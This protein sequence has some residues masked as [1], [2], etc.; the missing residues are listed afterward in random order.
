M[1]DATQKCPVCGAILPAGA[2]FCGECGTSLRA[3]GAVPAAA[4]HTTNPVLPWFLAGCAVM[5]VHA[6]VI[7]VAVKGRTSAAPVPVESSAAPFAGGGAPSASGAPDISNMTPR[8]A[9]DRLYNRIARASEAGDTAQVAFFAPMAINA[10]ANV[11]PK[12][13]DARLHIGLIQIGIGNT[14]AARAEADTITRQNGLH[15]FG[16]LL[17]ARAAEAS[18]D[19]ATMREAYRAFLANYDAEM[20]KNLPEYE[21]HRNE[22]EAARTAARA[23]AGR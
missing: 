18:N 14:A 22:L 5:A 11:T 19:R 8:E 15:L 9:A 16:P 4:R 20:R 23:A 13:A 2:K 12:D 10:Y 7:I 6:A 17:K 3:G 1:T 21:Q